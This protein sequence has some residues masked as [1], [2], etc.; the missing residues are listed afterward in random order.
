MTISQIIK[1]LREGY[2]ELL[3]VSE[4]NQVIDTCATWCNRSAFNL[5][6]A[7]LDLRGL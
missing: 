2:A 7:E 3:S 1:T 4:L 6:D 5:A